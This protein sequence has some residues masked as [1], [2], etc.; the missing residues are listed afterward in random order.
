MPNLERDEELSAVETKRQRE[1][2]RG[3]R[4]K[5]EEGEPVILC[6]W[7]RLIG[8]TNPGTTSDPLQTSRSRFSSS[9]KKEK[10]DLVACSY[11]CS[12]LC[13]RRSLGA[14]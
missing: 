1:R 14:R 12:S 10:S 5:N 7:I 8:E 4:E 11:F 13:R 3:E 6:S 2:E 9:L